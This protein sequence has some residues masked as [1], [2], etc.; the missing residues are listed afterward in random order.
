LLLTVAGLGVIAGLI[1]TAVAAMVMAAGSLWTIL[2]AERPRLDRR[3]F[4]S[5]LSW[6]S[7]NQL[8]TIFQTLNYR[9]DVVVLQFFRPL[10]QVGLYVVAQVV[11]ELALML[12]SS[13]QGV[14]PIVSGEEQEDV[15][16]ATTTAS[17]RH[18]GVLAL[19]AIIVT[20]VFGPA[21]IALGF[22]S[23]FHGA[24]LPMLLL[25]PGI[26]FL[27]TG[28]VAAS[29]LAGRG[30]PGLPAAL[31]GLATFVTVSLDFALIP[32]LGMYG[33]VV[34]S[35]AAYTTYGLVSLVALSRVSG[36]DWRGLVVPTRRDLRIYPAAA[37]RLFSGLRRA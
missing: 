7:R 16:A 3:L 31:A 9:L 15:R 11:A 23:D 37:G 10:S 35:V 36:I 20:A 34:A 24:I 6:G 12:S 21:V 28:R 27:G 8:A 5:M 2:R 19:A 14:L 29:V 17:T 18:H 26:W 32:W 25:L 33:A 1:A 4:G 30:R 13:F 22:G